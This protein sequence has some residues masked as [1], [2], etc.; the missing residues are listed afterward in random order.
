MEKAA[1]AT[2]SMSTA[3]TAPGA[4]AIAVAIGMSQK[5]GLGM[6]DQP[7]RAARPGRSGDGG[8]SR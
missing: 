3:M 4:P 1:S 7:R 2:R 8:V 5:P 6:A